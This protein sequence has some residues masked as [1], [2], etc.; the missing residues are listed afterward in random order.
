MTTT[1]R[2]RVKEKP[3]IAPDF[4][5]KTSVLKR[6]PEGGGDAM[7]ISSPSLASPRASR[8]AEAKPELWL[9]DFKITKFAVIARKKSPRLTRNS[10]SNRPR[11]RLRT[12]QA[13]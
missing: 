9:A 12:G 11:N 1:F 2:V 3:S 5:E 10:L 4:E 8:D 13:S 6:R 7:T